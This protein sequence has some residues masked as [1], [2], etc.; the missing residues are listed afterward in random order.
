M[1]VKD[2][3]TE[4]HIKDTAKR[5][6]LTEGRMLAT[7]QDIADAAGVNRTLLHY[8]FRSRDELFQ[9]VFREAVT[10]LRGSLHT[11]MVSEKPFRQK[12]E[13]LIDVYFHEALK[14]PYL[15][16]FIAVQLNED[17]GHYKSIFQELPG[18]DERRKNFLKQMKEEAEKGAIADIKPLH[19]F[20]SLFSLLAYPFIARPIYQNMFK[21]D[22]AAYNKLLKERKKVIISLMFK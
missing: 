19:F 16:T 10:N 15:E 22:D 3:K 7:T 2:C 21:M 14:Y 1:P 9:Q 5:V 17:P 4:H 12:I 11:V 8:Y 20:I 6:F 18:G 13:D